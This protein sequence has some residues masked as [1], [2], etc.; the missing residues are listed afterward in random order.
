MFGDKQSYNDQGGYPTPTDVPSE[1]A[2]RAFCIPGSTEWLALVMGCLMQL[3]D[4]KNWQVFDG[5]ITA[6]DAADAAQA[7]IDSGYD[8]TCVVSSDTQTPFW[9]EDSGDDVDDTLPI[10]EQPWY[11]NLAD[12]VVTAFLA[13]SFTPTAAVEFVTTIRQIRVW[14]RTRNYGAIASVLWDDEEIA[15][16]DTYSAAD[17][18][19]A[20]EYYAPTA[21]EHTLRIE[22][23][24]EHNPDAT[25]LDDGYAIEIVRGDLR[26][27]IY[28]FMPDT[29]YD[30]DTDTVQVTYDGT[31][32]VDAPN[33]DPRNQPTL[34]PTAATN[35]DAAARMVA[36]LKDMVDGTIA[37]LNA[38]APE[39]GL[40]AFLITILELFGAWG[41]LL[42]LAL[43]IAAALASIGASALAAAF[44]TSVWDTLLCI[45]Y[46]RIQPDGFVLDADLANINAA[47]DTEIGGTAATVLHLLI[48]LT[49]RAALNDAAAVR[50]ET[51][52]AC[53]DCECICEGGVQR[54]Q[55]Y[56]FAS[57]FSLSG[58]ANGNYVGG[59]IMNYDA[60]NDKI[61]GHQ[62]LVNANVMYAGVNI[63]A[64]VFS[65]IASVTVV[66]NAASCR[67]GVGTQLQIYDQ[68][69]THLVYA[70]GWLTEGSNRL[71]G[72][73][74]AGGFTVTGIVTVR[75]AVGVQAS[76]GIDEMLYIIICPGEA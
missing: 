6:A 64:G 38:D 62:S 44:T 63:N 73:A 72:Y 47:I 65:K 60:T 9:D 68:A 29:R 54:L 16:V 21:S 71:T 37:Q 11:E 33:Q 12:W 28:P 8:G 66:Y 67:L 5:G 35:C 2:T 24:G 19:Q 49:G 45:I 1:L 22:H 43:A 32:W 57:P 75:I 26:Q 40:A 59:V 48:Q 36:L 61:V 53:D 10:A 51:S 39:A 76:C 52:T 69:Q 34:P 42:A 18:V 58:G 27:K 50:S 70:S 41:L 17:G 4:E 25:P 74:P 31:N 56:G 13:Q 3:A 14:F 20:F 7:I 30:E 46:C 55:G 15:Q 23:T